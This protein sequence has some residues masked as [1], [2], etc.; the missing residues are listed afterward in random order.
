MREEVEEVERL[1]PASEKAFPPWDSLAGKKIL[2]LSRKF[3]WQMLVLYLKLSQMA[4]ARLLATIL[5]F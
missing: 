4:E 2:S 1:D 5:W 3:S